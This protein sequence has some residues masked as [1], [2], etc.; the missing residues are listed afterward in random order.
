MH[1]ALA[2]T[3]SC[4]VWFFS[5]SRS[6]LYAT[7][8]FVAMFTWACSVFV[9]NFVFACAT[10]SHCISS[11]CSRSSVRFLIIYIKSVCENVCVGRR[12]M[13]KKRLRYWR[14]RRRRARTYTNGFHNGFFISESVF[15]LVNQNLSRPNGCPSLFSIYMYMVYIWCARTH[16]THTH[17]WQNMLIVTSIVMIACS[18]NALA[19]L[20]TLYIGMVS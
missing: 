16:K 19:S 20:V 17:G 7:F 1:F 2:A 14:R 4:A 9:Y 5:F 3:F 13:R 10:Y 6:S 12:R 11:F 8:N 18:A 15:V